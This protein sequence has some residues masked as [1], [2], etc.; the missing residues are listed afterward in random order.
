MMPSEENPQPRSG[1]DLGPELR[2][3]RQS[4]GVT[5]RAVEQETGIS[6][7]Y[8]SQLETGKIA[9]PS[10]NYLYKLADFYNVPYELLM[11]HAGYV[12]RE[13]EQDPQKPRRLSAAALATISDLTPQ[14]EEE[15]MNYVA[16]LR[17][18][19]RSGRS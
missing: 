5:L 10:P 15:L 17:S 9:K 2:R 3:I 12:G 19:R 7:A 13:P 8:L 14:E 11:E 18:R 6:N 1:A 4:R 16:Y